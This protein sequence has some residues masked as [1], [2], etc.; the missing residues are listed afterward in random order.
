MHLVHFFG[1]LRVLIDED[2]GRVASVESVIP[3]VP[4]TA[5]SGAY[6]A[7]AI[8]DAEHRIASLR[9]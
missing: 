6:I 3:G 4:V 8:R 1:A 7:A 9:D 2:T 5:F